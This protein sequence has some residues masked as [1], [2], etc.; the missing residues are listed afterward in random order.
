MTNVSAVI[1]QL[2]AVKKE[3]WVYNKMLKDSKIDDVPSRTKLVAI[4][5]RLSALEDKLRGY[6][7]ETGF[8]NSTIKK[9]KDQLQRRFK[10]GLPLAGVVG[11]AIRAAT[12]AERTIAVVDTIGQAISQAKSSV[13]GQ[14]ALD[15]VSRVSE[16]IKGRLIGT[17]TT[18]QEEHIQNKLGRM[19]TLQEIQQTVERLLQDEEFI[20]LKFQ[21][22]RKAHYYGKMGKLPPAS[23]SYEEVRQMKKTM[24]EKVIS[25]SLAVAC[26]NWEVICANIK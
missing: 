13:E 25:W 7:A 20:T 19:L 4:V 5:N 12:M 21:A 17:K 10:R 16:G 18:E 24:F 6:I 15:A 11:G 3:C 2:R 9:A 26:L 1:E 23:L 22:I 14:M 8:I